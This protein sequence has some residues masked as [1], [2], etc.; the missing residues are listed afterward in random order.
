MTSQPSKATSHVTAKGRDFFGPP[1]W[2]TLHC[3]AVTYTP[4]KAQAFIDL[5]N[6]Y[7]ALLP[8]A[9]CSKNLKDK[10]KAHPPEPYLKSNHDLFFYT[11]ILHDLANV[12][13]TQ[14]HPETPKSSPP[15]LEV[16]ERYF[17]ALGASCKECDV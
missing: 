16:K 3:V 14:H 11:Y 2:A 10:I 15:Y 4:D 7:V 8:C 17:R 12:H 9:F 13:I 1:M 5:L 6:S